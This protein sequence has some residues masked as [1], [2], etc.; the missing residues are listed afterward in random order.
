MKWMVVLAVNCI[1][2]SVNGQTARPHSNQ[3]Q[4]PPNNAR[5]PQQQQIGKVP[6][7]TVTVNTPNVPEQTETTGNHD[8]SSEKPQSYFQRLIAPETLP[9]SL[10]CLIGF[11]GVVAAFYTLGVIRKQTKI[12]AAG[13]SQWIHVEPRSIAVKE[14]MGEQNEINFMF[15]AENNT[16]YPLKMNKIVIWVG[17]WADTWDTSIV[18]DNVTLPPSGQK[19]SPHYFYAVRKCGNADV[20]AFKGGTVYTINGVIY[21]VDCLGKDQ[22]Q[23]FGGLYACAPTKFEWLEPLGTIPDHEVEHARIPKYRGGEKFQKNYKAN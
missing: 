4:Q 5:S 3:D 23:G 19:K 7:K 20:K 9:N 15:Q 10:L 8:K 13:M 12:Q 18:E 14:G 6:V 22:V 1:A 21:F 16:A 11:A 17:Y 2:I